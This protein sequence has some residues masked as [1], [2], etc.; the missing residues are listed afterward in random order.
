VEDI[1]VLVHARYEKQAWLSHVVGLWNI[2]LVWQDDSAKLMIAHD[3]EAIIY[4]GECRLDREC[5]I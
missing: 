4:L 5:L 2:R 3:I 1:K